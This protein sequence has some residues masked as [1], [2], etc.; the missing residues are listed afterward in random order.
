MPSRVPADVR[1]R[2]ARIRLLVL[3]VDGVLTDGTLIYSSGGEEQKR[4]SVRDGIAMRLLMKAG[5]QV[6]VLS[7]RSSEAVSVRCRELGLRADLVV[8]GS[9]DKAADLDL[10]EEAVGVSDPEVAAMGDDLPDLPLLSRAGFAACPA[11][12]APEVIVACDLVC[13]ADGGR[14]AVREFAE[15]LLKAQDRWSELLREWKT[16][17]GSRG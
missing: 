14:G 3:D 6:A 12:A 16:P 10:L 15:L 1:Q 2:L 11:D 8:Q 9:R 13:G 4:F 5:V 17:E 7:G